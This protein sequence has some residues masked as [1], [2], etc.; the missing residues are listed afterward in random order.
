MKVGKLTVH[1]CVD[2]MSPFQMTTTWPQSTNESDNEDNK[3]ILHIVGGII[4]VYCMSMVFCGF[5]TEKTMK[6]LI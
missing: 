3:L 2:M 6:K 4:I 5:L 1:K